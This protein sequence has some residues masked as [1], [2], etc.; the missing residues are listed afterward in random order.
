MDIEGDIGER[1]PSTGKRKQGKYMLKDEHGG[2]RREVRGNVGR[3]RSVKWGL[4]KR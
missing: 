2:K 1:K 4:K 3:N